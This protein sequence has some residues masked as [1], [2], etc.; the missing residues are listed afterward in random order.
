MAYQNV[1]ILEGGQAKVEAVRGTPESALTRWLYPVL[2]GLV[3]NYNQEVEDEPESTRTYHGHTS[4]SLG[5]P[6][7]RISYE[8]IVSYEDLPW[9]FQMAL[10]GGV[11]GISTGSTPPGYTYTFVPATATDDL[12]TFTLVAGDPGN[13]YK[14]SRCAIN[15][16]TVRWDQAQQPSWRMTADIWARDMTA[17]AAYT[18]AIPDRNRE[19]VQARGTLVYVDEPGGTIGTT[20]VTNEIRSG[21][22][23]V[24]NQLEDKAFSENETSVSA[25]FARG[26]QLITGELVREFKTDTEFAK[27]RAGT[28][29]RI[30]VQRTGSTIGAT[31]TTDKRVRI[32]VPV[33]VLYAP[34]PGHVGQ[35]R[36]L[37]WGFTGYKT[38]ADPVPITAAIVNALVTL[39]L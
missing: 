20:Q 4:V 33:A 6:E 12:S 26:E 35:N 31:P 29:R 24:D 16:L 34:R 2:G 17:G 21:S 15:S 1:M 19:R 23:T 30:R 7:V 18:G 37:T 11:A 9:W 38:V 36:I 5:L 39:P 3:V 22:V 25:D 28:T 10:K 8:E 13:L 27:M 32:D 14:F